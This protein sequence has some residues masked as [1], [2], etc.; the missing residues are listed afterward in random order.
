MDQLFTVATRN[1]QVIDQRVGRTLKDVVEQLVRERVDLVG[2]N[3]NGADLRGANLVGAQ[4][5]FA[6]LEGANLAGAQLNGANLVHVKARDADM[7]TACFYGADLRRA[8]LSGTRL[9]DANFHGARLQ[10]AEFQDARLSWSSHDLI[11]EILRQHAK[12]DV[13]KL[14]VAGLVLIDRSSCWGDFIRLNDPLT[15]WALG[16]LASYDVDGESP[17]PVRERAH[18]LA[19]AR[20]EQTPAPSHEALT[21]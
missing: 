15:D 7:E 20:A 13:D 18:Q 11:A 8:D 17:D 9:A 21:H 6:L 16:V 3:L 14:K 12:G 1:G 19:R 5:R 10:C 4:L 2:A